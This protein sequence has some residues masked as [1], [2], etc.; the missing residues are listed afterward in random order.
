M[1]AIFR[2][3]GLSFFAYYRPFVSDLLVS[4][5]GVA[6]AVGVAVMGVGL[7]SSVSEPPLVLSIFWTYYL[8]SFAAVGPKGSSSR[9]A[10]FFPGVGRSLYP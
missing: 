9:V 7:L 6:V 8:P 1:A 2:F 5:M 3:N 4:V 10:A